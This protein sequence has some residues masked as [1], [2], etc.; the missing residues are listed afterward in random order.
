MAPKLRKVKKLPPPSPKC[1]YISCAKLT[2]IWQAYL[3][4]GICQLTNRN[5]N[6]L[7]G[8]FRD[9]VLKENTWENKIRGGNTSYNGL[10][11]ETRIKRGTFFRLQVYE[12]VGDV[13]ISLVVV[14]KRI[15]K[16]VT[17]SAKRPKR[18]NRGI[19]WLGKSRE[20]YSGLVINSCLKESA[21]TALKGSAIFYT[22]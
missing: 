2:V 19:L 16:S 13:G 17:S 3:R 10:Y 11:G 12:R 1:L 14:C 7:L 4:E 15:R 9:P 6:V 5:A 22:R 20:K 21:F 18:A 8:N